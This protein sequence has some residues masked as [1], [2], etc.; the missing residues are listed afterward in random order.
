MVILQKKEK[1]NSQIYIHKLILKILQIT[2]TIDK[3]I[4]YFIF[5]SNE[6]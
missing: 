3:I 1:Q 4:K 5:I 2:Y 6:F